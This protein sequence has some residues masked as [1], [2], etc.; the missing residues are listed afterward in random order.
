M[1]SVKSW[2]LFLLL[3]VAV[4]LVAQ[5]DATM[6]RGDTQT[7][8]VPF[9]YSVQTFSVNSPL[10]VVINAS[11]ELTLGHTTLPGFNCT[12]TPN[13]NT[14]RGT[15]GAAGSQTITITQVLSVRTDA[16]RPGVWTIQLVGDGLSGLSPKTG[17]ITIPDA[18]PHVIMT[19]APE[20]LQRGPG[21]SATSDS[22]TF[23]NLG[24]VATV[25]SVAHSAIDAIFVFEGE[26]FSSDGQERFVA[27]VLQPGEEHTVQIREL[28]AGA[29]LRDSGGTFLGQARA[30][31]EGVDPN[32]QVIFL[33]L[34]VSPRPTATPK[35]EPA[36]N[37]ADVSSS[38]GGPNPT[39]SVTFTN[40]GAGAANGLLFSDAL[41]V[42]FSDPSFTLQP[43]ET[44]AAQFT[45]D[46]AKQAVALAT[47]GGGSLIA[48]L[49]F[50][51]LLPSSSKT[52]ATSVTPLG[53]PPGTGSVSVTLVSTIAPATANATI[54]PLPDIHGQLFLAGVGHAQGSV[55]LFISDLVIYPQVE[56][57]NAAWRSRSL[58]DVDLYY[59][60]LG[61]GTAQKATLAPLATPNVAA[62]GDLVGTVYGTTNQIGSL[63]IRAPGYLAGE[64]VIGVSANVFNVS[65]KSGTYGT[66]IPA[67]TFSKFQCGQDLTKKLY[68]TGLRKDASG[69]TNFYVQETCGSNAKVTLDFYDPTGNKIGSTTTDVP[70]FAA[71]QLGTSVVPNGAVSAILSHASGSSGG[72]VAYATPVDEASG[73]TWAQVDWPNLRGYTG[74]MPVVI[75]VAGALPGANNTYFRTDL[76]VMNTGSTAGSGTLRFYNRTGETIDRTITLNPLQTATYVDVTTGLFGI[77]TPHVGYLVFTPASGTFVLTSRNYSTPVGSNATF[78]TAVPTLALT[79]AMRP[80]Q[81]RRI[82]GIEDASP[83]TIGTQRGATYRSNFGL[84]ETTGQPAT[85]KVTAYYTYTSGLTSTVTGASTTIDLSARQFVLLGVGGTIFGANRASLGDLHNI[86]LEFEVIGGT[87]NVVPF[88]SSVDNGSGDSTF[89]TE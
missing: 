76:S 38:S 13:V 48:T 45:I 52:A 8:T 85:V 32:L 88:V 65:G 20:G 46:L 60:P 41:W 29:S 82:G 59:T 14:C 78:G 1:R 68:L 36:S 77:T 9:T 67:F 55:G 25:V 69:H 43:G 61:G 84:I 37:R 64:G 86:T 6:K 39:R 87:G 47:G 10:V 81:V 58:A 22:M 11:P 7:F 74:N 23:K 26:G 17:L 51:F 49:N 57:G 30:S 71:I 35:P 24:N 83:D 56:F 80:G 72:F 12:E 70:A 66:S 54:P 21:E 42:I 33:R 50:R 4:P 62:F 40:T 53:N 44:K 16:S 28:T 2:S 34:V 18:G 63:Q 31:G 73:D 5:M 19:K 15:M 27:F 89:R 3:F 79:S 75:P